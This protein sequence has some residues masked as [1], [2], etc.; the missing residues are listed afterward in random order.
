MLSTAM[1]PK[2]HQ[3]ELSGFLIEFETGHNKQSVANG[4]THV[5]Q[6]LQQ[7]DVWMTISLNPANLQTNAALNKQSTLKSSY[8]FECVTYGVI[9]AAY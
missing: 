2:E 4:P 3:Q 7:R 6:V 9:I 5:L 8:E 1:K